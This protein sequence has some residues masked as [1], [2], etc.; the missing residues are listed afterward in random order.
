MPGDVILTA[1]DVLSSREYLNFSS[2]HTALLEAQIPD[3]FT[4]VLH[5]AFARMWDCVQRHVLEPST[6]VTYLEMEKAR[7]KAPK[8]IEVTRAVHEQHW[9]QAPKT[10]GEY[11][12][13]IQK[14][15]DAM[16]SWVINRLP[17]FWEWVATRAEGNGY[18][19]NRRSSDQSNHGE[20]YGKY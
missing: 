15:T 8:E 17:V 11:F 5:S 12:G 9:E 7:G 2:V 13:G 6:L 3:V 1:F 18:C 20:T 16:I 10:I 14:R 4:H 19:I